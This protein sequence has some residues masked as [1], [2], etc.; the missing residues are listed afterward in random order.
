MGQGPL[1]DGRADCVD[2]GVR[3][4]RHGRGRGAE[5]ADVPDRRRHGRPGH[6]PLF[7]PVPDQDGQ[8]QALHHAGLDGGI[9]QRLLVERLRRRR[10]FGHVPSIAQSPLDH[11]GR[12]GDGRHSHRTR[13]P[14]RQ[15]R[16]SRQRAVPPLRCLLLHA[17]PAMVRLDGH[18]R[19]HAAV[20]RGDQLDLAGQG[21]NTPRPPRP[22]ADCDR[23]AHH[24]RRPA[25]HEPAVAQAAAVHAPPMAGAGDARDNR[26]GLRPSCRPCRTPGPPCRFS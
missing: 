6:G 9:L 5:P 23:P 25:G 11:P 2:A 1:C 21:W 12:L 13:A 19:R 18:P 24:D 22:L 7:R 4:V 16:H 3:R 10:V 26:H 15:R 17:R 14:G 20:E 8:G